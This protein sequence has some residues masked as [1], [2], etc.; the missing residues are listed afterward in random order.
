MVKI[1]FSFVPLLGTS[2]GSVLGIFESLYK[3]LYKEEDFLVA[4]AT[5]ILLSITVSLCSE[6]FGFVV[7]LRSLIIWLVGLMTGIFSI[8]IMNRFS[9]C[10]S[11]TQYKLFWAMLVH[12]IPEGILIGISLL[13]SSVVVAI[14][15]VI[16]I[17]LQNIPDGM[18]VSMPLVSKKGRKIALLFGILSGAVE[19]VVSLSIIFMVREA[20]VVQI[21][22]PLLI[23]FSLSA[24]FLIAMEL[25]D[26][27]INKK[28]ALATCIISSIF[29]ICI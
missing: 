17:T 18:V 27:C 24:I 23:G 29:I 7:N 21:I 11:S 10:T 25:M 9:T 5:G 16:S 14:P 8:N 4:V 13:N 15:L 28:V 26:D 3:K 1:L 22:E 19:P 6:S 20:S 2:I 12:N